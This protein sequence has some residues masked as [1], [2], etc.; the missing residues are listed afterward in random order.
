MIFFS[1]MIIVST[2]LMISSDGQA[3]VQK[4]Q[5]SLYP[6]DNT[7]AHIETCS[8]VETN[9]PEER[10]SKKFQYYLYFDPDYI[11]SEGYRIMLYF[12]GGQWK[13]ATQRWNENSDAIQYFTK[14]GYLIIDASYRILG[15]SCGST[16]VTPI[17]QLLDIKMA[18]SRVIFL[19]KY[20]NYLYNSNDNNTLALNTN[21]NAKIIILGESAGGH[22]AASFAVN[23]PADMKQNLGGVVVVGAPLDFSNFLNNME[24]N[25]SLCLPDN[26]NNCCNNS[27]YIKQCNARTMT[28]GGYEVPVNTADPKTLL[29]SIYAYYLYTPTNQ[30][31]NFVNNNTLQNYVTSSTVPFLLIVSDMDSWVPPEQSKLFCE[32]FGNPILDLINSDMWLFS[33]GS[34]K[35]KIMVLQNDNSHIPT[36]TKKIISTGLG[37]MILNWALNKLNK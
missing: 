29:E 28:L 16:L 37:E 17:D 4:Y 19:R 11:P 32:A 21:I 20:M 15:D 25:S 36:F 5:L 18:F 3:D 23:I 9:T 30:K 22:L 6:L 12:H 7:G 2:L 8:L 10:G 13:S 33:C 27:S 1:A 34:G 31:D 14:K 24:H 26:T 35:S